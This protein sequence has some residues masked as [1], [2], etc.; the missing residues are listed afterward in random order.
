MDVQRPHPLQA[1]W[2]LTLAS[3][4]ADALDAALELGLFDALANAASADELA[5]RLQLDAANTAYLLELLWSMEL[6]ERA[7]ATLPPRYRRSATAA[8]YLSRDAA[9]Y[10]GEAWSYR[11]R[12]LRHFGAGLRAAVRD[13]QAAPAPS[14]AASAH[15]WASAAQRQIG[16][17][18][19]AV[20]VDAALAVLARRPDL[21]A[22]GAARRFLDLGCGP[23]WI[24]IAIA[25][26]RP[27]WHGVAFDQAETVAVASANIEQAGLT[28]RLA[29][30]AGDLQTDGI[31][32]GY[33]VIWC[34]SVLHF[35][36]DTDA[37][38]HKI[39]AALRPGGILICA[40]AEIAPTPQAAARV[41]PYYL[42]MRMLGRSVT[43]HG[44]LAG[45]LRQAGFVHV[46]QQESRD[47]PM[48]PVQVI[49]GSRPA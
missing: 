28:A 47:F 32:D 40:Q 41:L 42:S 9:T 33:D 25:Q 26:A 43:R 27:Q 2:N 7:E 44:E 22:G 37:A 45:A 8:V 17:E 20:T 23:A 4:Q 13:G 12:S 21:A 16:Q 15:N 1:Y 38:L 18:Q 30:L 14:M 10:C 31:G 36:A 35:V 48:A 3:V 34:S 46:E 24:A 11:L 19:R 5:R 6:L 49:I 29:P 39:H